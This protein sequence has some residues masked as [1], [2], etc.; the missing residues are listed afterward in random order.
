VIDLLKENMGEYVNREFE[1]PL[2][3][4]LS[5]QGVTIYPKS[6]RMINSA[7]LMVSADIKDLDFKALSSG[8]S[9]GGSCQ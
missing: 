4:Y 6:I 5:Q 8:G 1:F 7:Y 2:D 9:Q 3:D